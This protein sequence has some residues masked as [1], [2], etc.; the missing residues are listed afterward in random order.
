MKAGFLEQ[1]RLAAHVIAFQISPSE[2]SGLAVKPLEHGAVAAA[3]CNEW[4]RD[5][6][7]TQAQ[8]P[9]AREASPG[10]NA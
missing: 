9:T 1:L 8:T 10:P 7:S 2:P 6:G 4:P 5:S 3:G